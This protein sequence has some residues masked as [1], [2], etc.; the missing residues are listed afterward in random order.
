V[1]LK[2][3]FYILLFFFFVLG[4]AA[5]EKDTV[6]LIRSLKL[7]A[8]DTQ[9]VNTAI[10]IADYF[11]RKD[12]DRSMQYAGLADSL[13]V[14]AGYEKGKA[15]AAKLTGEINYK[16]G[17]FKEALLKFD[18]AQE[19]Y[20]QLDEENGIAEC[21]SQKSAVF[22]KLGN[23]ESAIKI[24]FE[25]LKTFEKLNNKAG[26]T[27]TYINIGLVY[28]NMKKYKEA[29]DFY[30]KAIHYAKEIN[31][32]LS[33]AACYNNL[34]AIY[35]D[36]KQYD[37][38]LECLN[39]SLAIKEKLGN[40]TAVAGTLNNI[41]VIYYET[42]NTKKA[43]EYFEKAF[44]IKEEI[45]DKNGMI[46]SCNNIGTVLFE[47]G[48]SARAL[49]YFNR[50]YKMAQETG[51]K[52][53][54]MDCLENLISFYKKANDY[55]TAF[56]YKEKFHLYKDSIF[57]IE[58]SKNISEIQTRF[59]S[60]KKQ[61]ENEILNLQLKNESFQKYIFIFAAGILV[62]LVFFIF[63]NGLQKQKVNKALEDKNKIIEQ[64]KHIVEE[65]NKDITD[66][67]KYAERIQTAIFPPEKVWNAIVP[68]SFVYFKPKDILSGDFYWVEEKEDLMFI[69]TA[70]CT[71]HGVPGALIS[72]VNYNLL[73]KAVLEKELTD[74]ADILN[75]VN[76]WLTVSLH[77]TFQESAMRDG[78][79]VALCV[80][81]KKTL[82]MEF[83]GANNPVYIFS[84]KEFNSLS[85]DKFPVGAFVEEH[86]QKFTTK[87]IQLHKGDVIYLFSDGYADQF[88][89]P[90][91]KKFKYKQLQTLLGEVHTLDMKEQR[92]ILE[93][94]MVE[95]K[96]SLE[97]VDDVLVVGI[98]I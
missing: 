17:D 73:N 45:G 42:F 90:K 21:K 1:S 86:L 18:K 83:A 44:K 63:R 48:A 4:S 54:A 64:Q 8:S 91:G 35:T 9:K 57:N 58:N 75:A 24:A 81:N 37:L 93:K 10:S 53:L 19:I 23:N 65:Q 98:R 67:I 82:S 89:G 97:Q 28:D 78:M 85:G 74:P 88:G 68:D 95:W 5:Q 76:N 16:R 66:S 80:I 59:E 32:Q 7:A 52:S 70:D 38:S 94:A 14:K 34:G 15:A 39:R 49:P 40:K 46:S 92:R 72:I 96:G 2:T 47:T 29:I 84:N 25:A 20:S 61:K 12:L 87:K 62:I 43:L 27:S 55:K 26:I 51:S 13:S 31:D 71:G 22:Y 79:D 30:N 11:L 36:E 6:A 69:A 41:G 33:I 56:D 50:A 3:T 60:E 77:Q